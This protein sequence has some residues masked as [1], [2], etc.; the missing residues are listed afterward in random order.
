MLYFLNALGTAPGLS[1]SLAI[2][3]GVPVPVMLHV[4]TALPVVGVPPIVT[5]VISASLH[6]V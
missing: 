4:L 3:A 1:T 2:V 5:A 6:V